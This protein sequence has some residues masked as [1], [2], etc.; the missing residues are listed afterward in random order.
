MTAAV[1]AALASMAAI[2]AIG[3]NDAFTKLL[4]HCDGADGSTSFPDDLAGAHT[5]TVGGNAQVDTSQFKFSGASAQFGGSGDFITLDGSSDFAFGTGDFTIDFWVYL[6]S[7]GSFTPFLT[8]FRA[9]AGG[10][11]P[12]IYINAPNL[13]FYTGSVDV[14]VTTAPSLSAWHHIAL[15]RAGTSTK[16]FVDGVQGG[17]TYTD[18]NSYLNAALRPAF[19]IGYDGVSGPLNGWMDEI[20]ISKGV[21]RW[22]ADF[23]PSSGPYS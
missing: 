11:Y 22:T 4:L 15:A 14:I 7:I 3:G 16:L 8:D 9:S 20:R 1:N 13:I 21:A 18:L 10:L 12:T 17:S 19:G 2:G 5:V 6:N 23:T